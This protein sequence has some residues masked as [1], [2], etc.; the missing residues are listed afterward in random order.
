MYFRVARETG[1]HAAWGITPCPGKTHL[2]A[3]ASARVLQPSPS[4]ARRTLPCNQSLAQR[5]VE[6]PVAGDIVASHDAAEGGEIPLCPRQ[7][8]K[9]PARFRPTAR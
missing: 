5:F 2:P 7:K 3:W 9:S 8:I 4:K 1:P 6:C